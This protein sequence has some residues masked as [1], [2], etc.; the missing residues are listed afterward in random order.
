MIP[1]RRNVGFG[2]PVTGIGNLFKPPTPLPPKPVYVAPP[3]P[4]PP[5]DKYKLLYNRYKPEQ[6]TDFVALNPRLVAE[7]EV[8]DNPIRTKKIRFLVEKNDKVAVFINSR[9][10][11]DCSIE[12]ILV[13][14]GNYK[15]YYYV[16]EVELEVN[17][18]P[19]GKQQLIQ[20]RKNSNMIYTISLRLDDAIPPIVHLISFNSTTAI[21][22]ARFKRTFCSRRC[23]RIFINDVE[24]E[25]TYTV[26]NN[27]VTA[28]FDEI[29]IN[30]IEIV[31]YNSKEEYVSK[32]VLAT[33]SS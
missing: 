27:I 28:I 22:E 6:F 19:N 12:E 11:C 10:Y 32:K 30:T 21:F 4:Q 23:F 1:V 15:F 26:K 14:I 2:S 9:K 5:V 18:L 3:P 17:L 13:E 25:F 20:V 24:I 7:G 16:V 31:V 29:E 33:L 8:Y